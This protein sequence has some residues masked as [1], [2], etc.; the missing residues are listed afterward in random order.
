MGH[1]YSIAGNQY[2]KECTANHNNYRVVY[3]QWNELLNS[4]GLNTG[5]DYRYWTDILVLV[6]L[7]ILGGLIDFHWLQ[8]PQGICSP[9]QNGKISSKNHPLTC[10]MALICS[11]LQS[12]TI[13]IEGVNIK[14]QQ[15]SIHSKRFVIL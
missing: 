5:M 10:S 6:F 11:S 1:S 15:N 8:V 2:T 9:S 7:H 4:C 3:N 12:N 13:L 14:S